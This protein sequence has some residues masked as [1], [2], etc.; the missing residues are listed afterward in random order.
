M[1]AGLKIIKT[2]GK[3]RYSSLDMLMF[4]MLKNG[5]CSKEWFNKKY[6]LLWWMTA[7]F[8]HLE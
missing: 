1:V 4:Q 6:E 7:H 5:A 2:I 3:R 8:Q